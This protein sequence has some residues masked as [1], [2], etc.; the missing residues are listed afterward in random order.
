MTSF[1]NLSP[2][3]RYS[4]LSRRSFSVWGG[5]LCFLRTGSDT[6]QVTDILF[7]EGPIL[8]GLDVTVQDNVLTL[9]PG[10]V[11]IDGH[12]EA[13]AGA[14]L[15]YDPATTSGADYVYAELPKYN[16]GYTQDPSLI[17]PATG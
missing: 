10:M 3:T 1:R 14:T 11:Y 9:T 7:K 17:N 4:P 5:I 16:Y 15:T 12:V 8:S 13:V 6:R 2:A